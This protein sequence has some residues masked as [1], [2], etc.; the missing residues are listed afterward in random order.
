MES[1]IIVMTVLISPVDSYLMELSIPVD[2]HCMKSP[3]PTMTLL[4]PSQHSHGV[5]S[6]A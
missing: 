2:S 1:H 5:T 3:V 4:T 6:P